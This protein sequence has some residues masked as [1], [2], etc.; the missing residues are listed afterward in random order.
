[1]KILTKQGFVKWGACLAVCATALPALAADP[2]NAVQ[3]VTYFPVPYARYNN[4]YPQYKL[5]IGTK[6]GSSFA[7]E[8]GKS[9]CADPTTSFKA[10][11]VNL[12]NISGSPAMRV[13]QDFKTTTASFGDVDANTTPSTFGL[14]FKDFY[15]KGTSGQTFPKIHANA[16]Q[17]GSPSQI[18]MLKG[19]LPSGCSSGQV[20]WESLTFDSTKKYLVCCDLDGGNCSQSC[21]GYDKQPKTCNATTTITSSLDSSYTGGQVAG[22]WND[23]SCACNCNVTYTASISG[24]SV[25]GAIR[26]EHNEVDESKDYDYCVEKCWSYT[27]NGTGGYVKSCIDSQW[28][29]PI[30]HSYQTVGAKWDYSSCTCDCDATDS[31]YTNSGSYACTHRCS[32]HYYN[33]NVSTCNAGSSKGWSWDDSGC[34]CDCGNYSIYKQSGSLCADRCV[35]GNPSYATAAN[36]CKDTGGTWKDDYWG[37]S[38]GC[39]C[40]TKDGK[41]RILVGTKCQDPAES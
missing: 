41:P 35:S 25:T 12:R 11:T 18:Y 17:T 3:M 39:N 24:Q 20:G 32:S 38:C 23:S 33:G 21:Q 29:N 10:N 30:T 9:G 31:D 8:A 19:T 5:D 27:N 37:S 14:S 36:D 1:M 4:I 13:S 6:S 7:V 2:T 34:E 16:L 15:L 22:T 28:Y 26:H 40:G